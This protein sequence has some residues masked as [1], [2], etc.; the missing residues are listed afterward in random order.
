MS[1]SRTHSRRGFLG[2][3]A[4]LAAASAFGAGPQLQQQPRPVPQTPGFPDDSSTRFPP[5]RKPDPRAI[6]KQ[7]QEDIKKDVARLTEVVAELQK[8][9]DDSDTKEVLSLDVVH[10]TE[11]IEKLAKQIRSLVRG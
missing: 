2:A 8:S 7:N 6:L 1:H 10:K 3:A 4:A 5:S 9:L 11:E